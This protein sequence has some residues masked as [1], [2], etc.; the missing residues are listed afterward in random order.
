[1]FDLFYVLLPC[2]KACIFRGSFAKPPVLPCPHHQQMCCAILRHCL[3]IFNKAASQ[4]R[5][6]RTLKIH[7][8]LFSETVKSGSFLCEVVHRAQVLIALL[9]S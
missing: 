9:I 7:V 8:S 3:I 2:G 4:A 1:M 6:N 5:R